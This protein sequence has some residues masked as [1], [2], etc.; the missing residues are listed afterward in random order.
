MSAA[1]PT[2]NAPFQTAN[3][4]INFDRDIRP[5][6]ETSC[7]RCHGPEKPRSNFRLD[8]RLS[9]LKGGNDS[10]N[11]IVPGNSAKSLLISYV[12]RQVP[13]MEMPPDGKGDPLTPQQIALLRAWIDEGVDWQTTNEAPSLSFAFAPAMRWIDVTGNRSKFQELEGV[14]TGFAGGVDQLS[15]TQQVS[16]DTKM[17]LTAHVIAP[18]RDIDVLYKVDKNDLGFIHAGFTDWRKYYNDIGG[19]NGTI[20]PSSFDLNRNLYVDNGRAWIDFGLTLPHAPE[21][22]LGYEFQFRNGNQANLDWGYANGKNI[23]PAVQSVDENT[24]SIKLAMTYDIDDWHLAD[25]ARVDFYH[26]NNVSSESQINLGGTSP[27]TFIN[28]GDKYHSTQGM[29]TLTVE[30][31]IQDWWL[32][33]GG[34][35]YSKLSGSDFFSQSTA[36]PSLSF[37]NT[38]SS[39]QITLE[40]QSQIFSLASLFKPLDYLSLSLGLQNEWTSEDGFGASIPNFD[41]GMNTPVDAND[42]SFKSSENGNLRFTQIPFS[43]IFADAQFEQ[44][45]LDMSQQETPVV[46]DYKTTMKDN[47]YDLKGG[48]NTSP[49][50][51]VAWNVQYGVKSSTTS[52]D[53]FQDIY[54]GIPGPTNGYPGFILDRKIRGNDFETKFDVH[55]A[56]WLKTTLTYQLSDTTYSS[57]TDPAFD[58]GLGQ[59]VSPGGFVPDGEYKDQTL[60]LNAVLTPVQQFYFSGSFTYTHS[61][62]STASNND[63]SIVPYTGDIFTVITTATYAYNPKTDLQASYIFSSSD[64]GQKNATAGQPAG[65]E[66]NRNE[67]LVGIT[68]KFTQRLSGTLRYQFSQ[69]TEPSSAGIN[70]FTAN[71]IFASI[72]Y[73][74]P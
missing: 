4:K 73:R 62:A 38:L 70:N 37:N 65:L 23:F 26:L 28:T 57:S 52:Y 35:Y 41:L 7:V 54:N 5:I 43:V 12:A 6:F 68:R 45:S 44:E 64:Y 71:G 16:P 20:T 25:N 18:G 55:P 66:F 24:H 9:A 1:D 56:R 22:V 10:T 33:S 32:F 46:Y 17:S 27:D 48:F 14:N 60:G 30:K 13:D 50:R 29:N 34:G 40:R 53:N 67:L 19:Y 47:R 63:P 49:W 61:H 11:D 8:N 3:L 15:A 21:I 39:Q 72:A 31:Q 58:F 74:W 59:S 2:N 69:Y 42:D 36:I 51:W